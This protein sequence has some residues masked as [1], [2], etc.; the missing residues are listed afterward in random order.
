MRRNQNSQG[1]AMFFTQNFKLALFLAK[2]HTYDC[3]WQ[4]KE[5]TRINAIHY[6]YAILLFRSWVL[7]L[8]IYSK[9]ISHSKSFTSHS[10]RFKNKT[11]QI[12]ALFAFPTF[13]NRD[14]TSVNYSP[15]QKQRA[16]RSWS[17]FARAKVTASNVQLQ[18]FPQDHRTTTQKSFDLDFLSREGRTRRQSHDCWYLMNTQRP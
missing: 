3:S 12:P 13:I 2:K 16:Q 7:S 18:V 15:H 9:N 6:N 11:H 8:A 17:S 5:E 4:K 10:K 1:K 14:P